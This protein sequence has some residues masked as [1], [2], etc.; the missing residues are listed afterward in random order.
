[1]TEHLLGLGITQRLAMQSREIVPQARVFSFDSGHIG[2]ADNLVAVWWSP[3]GMLPIDL[4]SIRDIEVALPSFDR[5]PQRLEGGCTRIA[6]D[7]TENP[8]LK[9]IYS[10]PDPDFVFFEPTK[11]SSSSSS[12]TSGNCSGS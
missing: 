2:L 7:P 11:V 6:N 8:T 12:P 10:C 5:C 1:M 4:P 9:V 3:S